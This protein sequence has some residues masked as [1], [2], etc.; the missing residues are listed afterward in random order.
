MGRADSAC[1]LPCSVGLPVVTATIS[2]YHTERYDVSNS[3]RGAVNSKGKLDENTLSA[4]SQAKRKQ[5]VDGA[6]KAFLKYGY[7]GTSMNRVAE[8][9]GVIKQTIYSHFAD[10]ESLFTAIIENLTLAHFRVEFGDDIPTEQ[11]PEV[12]LRK[13]ASVF[14]G[15][16]NDPSYIALMRTVIGESDRF[17]ELA[18]LY[19][20]TVIKPGIQLLTRYLNAHPELQIADTEAAARI[21]CGSLV[22]H[23]LMQHILYG[24]EII[25]YEIDRSIE[26][27]I[28]LLLERRPS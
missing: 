7:A 25:P 2:Y 19:T 8:E 13:L 24:K 1:W 18:R 10:K 17:P 11:T 26:M 22:S 28:M 12:A 4:F 3:C 20:R 9:A 23:I 14:S 15:R 27:L 16:Q 6:M 21:F 5:I